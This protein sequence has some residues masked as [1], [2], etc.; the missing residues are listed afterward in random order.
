MSTRTRTSSNAPPR[1]LF[2]PKGEV[3]VLTDAQWIQAN[4]YTPRRDLRSVSEVYTNNARM[5]ATDYSVP[6]RVCGEHKGIKAE[7]WHSTAFYTE[8]YLKSE[9]KR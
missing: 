1:V 5:K 2:R 6:R 7:G 3:A 4:A 8:K 9:L